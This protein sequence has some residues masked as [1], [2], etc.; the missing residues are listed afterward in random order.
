MF[1]QPGW[2]FVGVMLASNVPYKL[3]SDKAFFDSWVPNDTDETLA[4]ARLVAGFQPI[5]PTNLAQ[6]LVRVA[7][8]RL[9]QL[10]RTQPRATWF[11]PEHEGAGC[12]LA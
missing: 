2:Y 8:Q 6:T 4:K 3:A 10:R 9:P 7:L 1:A 11:G 12:L 5:R